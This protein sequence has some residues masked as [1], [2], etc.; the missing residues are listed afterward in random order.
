MKNEKTFWM[1]VLAGFVTLA[2]CDILIHQ[3]WLAKTYQEL[4]HYWRP[5][6][7]MKERMWLIFLSEFS[8][9]FLLAVIFPIGHEKKAPVAEG[10]RFGVL[11]GLL[12]YLPGILM[13]HYVYPYP[14]TLL[15]QWFVAGV[16]EITLAGTVISLA[17]SRKK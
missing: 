1:A 8:L 12:I 17:Y 9:A 7:E 10:I 5:E 6:A 11:M 15:A 14:T 13:K 2:A 4:A 16:G 3:V